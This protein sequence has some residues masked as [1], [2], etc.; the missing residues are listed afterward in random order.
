V[1]KPRN[2]KVKKMFYT[3]SDFANGKF[4][5]DWGDVVVDIFNS[6]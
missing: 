2:I 4:A 5:L 3:T 6:Q 1:A